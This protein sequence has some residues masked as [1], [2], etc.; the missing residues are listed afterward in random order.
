MSRASLALKDVRDGIILWRLWTLLGWN[1]ILQRYRRSIFGPFWLTISMAVMVVALGF[2]YSKLFEIA[3]NDFIPFLCIGLLVW[4]YISSFLLE[5]GTLYV[6]SEAYVKQIRLPYSTYALRATWSK[7]IIFAHNFVIYFGVIAYFKIWPG[8]V[9]LLAI[10]GFLLITLNGLMISVGL[11]MASARF[12]DIPQLIAS[13]VQIVFFVTPII[14]KPEL[15]K[16]HA[17][18]AQWNPFYSFIEIVRAPLLGQ[19]PPAFTYE[20]VAVITIV[21]ALVLG[22]FFVRYRSR[23]PYWV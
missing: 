2:L 21:N 6:S 1:D 10:P 3:I 8:P 5:G 13:L 11:G 7:V 23:I 14:W 16:G 19:L 15:L 18:L 20:I 4:G 12:R 17:Y 9:A 22:A